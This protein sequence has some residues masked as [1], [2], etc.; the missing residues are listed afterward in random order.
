LWFEMWR[1]IVWLLGIQRFKLRSE[2]S[3]SE[4]AFL[5]G[6][7]AIGILIIYFVYL[8]KFPEVVDSHKVNFGFCRWSYSEDLKMRTCSLC[9]KTE[10]TPDELLNE[11][12]GRV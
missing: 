3:L 4:I 6:F 2:F 10:A 12:V 11:K 5:F 8:C 9:S 1:L 7:T